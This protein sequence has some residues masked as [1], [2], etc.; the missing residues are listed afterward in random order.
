MAASCDRR[1]GVPADDHVE[2]GPLPSAQ[3]RSANA[4][5]QRPY[6]L[7]DCTWAWS[8]LPAACRAPRCSL[9]GNQKAHQSRS[10]TIIKHNRVL[11]ERNIVLTILT[12]RIPYVQKDARI[13]IN[14]LS[15]GFFRIIAHFGFMETPT[16]G[17]IIECCALKEFVI[18]EQKTSFFLGRDTIIPTENLVWR[19]GVSTSLWQ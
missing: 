12:D 15:Q 18:E 5:A 9:R 3:E 10:C 14:D 17:E 6:R 8:G 13:E 4:F 11:H 1:G 16:I 2:E 7:D 19:G